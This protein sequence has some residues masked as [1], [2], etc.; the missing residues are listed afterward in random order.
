[1]KLSVIAHTCSG[2]PI[3]DIPDMIIELQGESAN[4][5]KTPEGLRYIR[6]TRNYTTDDHLDAAYRFSDLASTT[7]YRRGF[8]LRCCR[9]HLTQYFV[10]SKQVQASE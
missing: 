4:I 10:Q 7:P 9:Y 5:L 2:K 8:Y 1:M 3:W 6:A